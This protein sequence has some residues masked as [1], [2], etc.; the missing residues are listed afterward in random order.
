MLQHA[1]GHASI[2]GDTCD[3]SLKKAGR[4]V[5]IGSEYG[6]VI[7]AIRKTELPG[8]TGQTPEQI[9]SRMAAMERVLQR[10]SEN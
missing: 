6:R 9:V 10:L 3:N 1:S 7:E 2:S 8:L 4:T 5:S